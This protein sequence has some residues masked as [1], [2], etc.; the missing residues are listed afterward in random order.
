M[1]IYMNFEGLKFNFR[2][3]GAGVPVYTP[4]VKGYSADEEPTQDDADAAAAALENLY[5]ELPPGQQAVIAQIVA[6]AASATDV[7]A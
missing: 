6:Q 4:E 2:P 5:H 1:P 3:T 7:A